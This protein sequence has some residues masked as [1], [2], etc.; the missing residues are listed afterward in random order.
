MKVI[1]LERIAKLGGVGDVAE[2]KAGYG[3]NFLLP[4]GKALRATE[5]NVKVF[6]SR[7]AEIEAANSEQKAAAEAQAKDLAGLTLVMA[8]ASSDEGKLFGSV[9]VRDVCEALAEKDLDIP[10]SVIQITSNIKNT[11]DYTVLIRLHAEVEVPVT[12]SVV[13]SELQA[14]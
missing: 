9:T 13:R 2:V 5:E 12:L 4:R 8:R 6:E 1:L 7:R 11:G 3:R 14:A 10:K